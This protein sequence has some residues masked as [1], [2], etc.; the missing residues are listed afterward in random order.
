VRWLPLADIGAWDAA[1]R[2]DAF[3]YPQLERIR[4]TLAGHARDP[5]RNGEAS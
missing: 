5:S 3:L 2:G 1:L 4:A